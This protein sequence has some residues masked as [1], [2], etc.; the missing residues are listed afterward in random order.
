MM[1]FQSGPWRTSPLLSFFEDSIGAAQ[2]KFIVYAKSLRQ[3]C[4]SR[5]SLQRLSGCDWVAGIDGC[6]GGWIAVLLCLQTNEHVVQL[7]PSFEAVLGLQP[8]PRLIAIDIP[9]GLL[10]ERQAGGRDCD[11]LARR[12]L[13]G[14]ASSVFSPPIR[15]LLGATTYEQVRGQGLS[16]QGVWYCA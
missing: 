3:D 2:Q 10:G 5:P 1:V 13:P 16:I 12:L 6:P 11:R 4:M 8:N 15:R 9:I 7:C 14:R